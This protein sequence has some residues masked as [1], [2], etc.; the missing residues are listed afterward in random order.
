MSFLLRTHGL[1]HSVQGNKEHR[2][3]QNSKCTKNITGF[4]FCNPYLNRAVLECELC[5]QQYRLTVSKCQ[6]HLSVLIATSFSSSAADSLSLIARCHS[7]ETRKN[8][9]NSCNHFLF[10]F[11]FL[12]NCHI[13]NFSFKFFLLLNNKITL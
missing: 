12:D 4:L 11:A 9:T 1:L 13:N 7:P 2:L 8:F 6:T 3:K 5:G 10:C